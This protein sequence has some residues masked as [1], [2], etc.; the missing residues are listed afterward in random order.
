MTKRILMM[1]SIAIIITMVGCSQQSIEVIT[2][3]KPSTTITNTSTTTTTIATTEAR[4][5]T[6]TA[7]SITKTTTKPTTSKPTTTIHTTTVPRTTTTTTKKVTTTKHTTTKKV[8]TES[9]CKGN[10][11]HWVSCGNMGKW[12]NTRDDIKAEYSRVANGWNTKYRNGEID[13]DTYIA[14]CPQGY[15][16]WS[17]PGCGKWTGNYH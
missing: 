4:T 8:T 3:T 2:T 15:E 7:T 14:N 11:D 10:N 17:C 1:I 5:T 16:C 6:N 13:W 9:Y 12:Y